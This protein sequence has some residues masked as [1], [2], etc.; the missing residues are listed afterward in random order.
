MG[1]NKYIETPE[2]FLKLWDEYKAH[3]DET[4]DKEQVPTGKGIILTLTK[5][6]PYIRMGF[7]AYVYR[8]KGFHVHQYIDNYNNAYEEYLGVV[9]CA[10]NEWEEDQVSGSLT[11]RYKSPNLV[12][13]LNNYSEKIDQTNIEKPIFGGIDL[14]IEHPMD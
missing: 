12:A 6:R 2:E 8:K 1:K 7:E 14:D 11:G 3:V 9:T 13:R 4:P 5:K 10:R